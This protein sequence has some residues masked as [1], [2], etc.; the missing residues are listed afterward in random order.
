[1]TAMEAL[2]QRMMKDVAKTTDLQV[3]PQK[4]DKRKKR[5][6]KV[7][8]SMGAFPSE[9]AEIRHRV[10]NIETGGWAS[11][12]D[13]RRRSFM[14]GAR[15][16]Q[17]EWRPRLIHVRGWAPLRRGYFP[18]AREASGG[19]VVETASRRASTRQNH[20]ISS[21][22]KAIMDDTDVKFISGTIG[23]AI[24]AKRIEVREKLVTVAIESSSAR[25]KAVRA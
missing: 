10:D 7:E 3:I 4:L 22:V 19:R 17:G 14:G 5:L 23:M 16:G 9:L 6:D 25:R 20:Q 1:M 21:E 13:G 2:F 8:T 15:P 11:S 24:G 12:S 18:Q